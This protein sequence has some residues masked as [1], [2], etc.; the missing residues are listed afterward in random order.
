MHDSHFDDE[1]LGDEWLIKRTRLWQLASGCLFILLVASWVY[2]YNQFNDD[3]TPQSVDL[4][5]SLQA[6]SLTQKYIQ[7]ETVRQ[8]TLT[9][10]STVSDP[11]ASPKSQ[12]ELGNNNYQSTESNRQQTGVSTYSEKKV[13]KPQKRLPPVTRNEQPAQRSLLDQKNSNVVSSPKPRNSQARSNTSNAT[14]SLEELPQ[15]LRSQFPNIE[16]N[17]FVVAENP[18]DS[19]VILDGSFYKINQVIAV[20]LV[21]REIG[22]DAIVVEFKGQKVSLPNK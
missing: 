19:F 15:D 10:S 1:L 3:K 2:F 18:Q 17:S 6:D 7:P 21:L 20:D 13:Y 12:A 9:S 8:E 22:K 16:I 4:E 14:L 11:Q 5:Q